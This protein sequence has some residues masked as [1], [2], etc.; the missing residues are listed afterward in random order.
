MKVLL[1]DDSVPAQNM[2]KKIL[3][4]AGYDVLTASNGLDAW[5]KIADSIP[6]IA[7]LDIFMPGYTGLEL[8]ARLRGAPN[9]AKLP[10]ILTVGKL[11]PYRPEDGEH[12]QSNAV[13]VK[14]FAANELISAVRSLI[15][16][17]VPAAAPEAE[18]LPLD[19][20]ADPLHGDPLP[21][22]PFAQPL[23]SHAAPPLA[24][25]DDVL[26]T[27]ELGDA[28]P[29]IAE[30]AAP[31][32][33]TAEFG[34]PE[35]AAGPSAEAA[36]STAEDEPLFSSFESA[37]APVDEPLVASGGFYGGTDEPL[38]GAEATAGEETLA[39]NPDAA[40]TPFSASTA[41]FL[42]QQPPASEG[43]SP[44]TE[45]DLEAAPLP[46]VA[47]ATAQADAPAIQAIEEPLL[48]VPEMAG[49]SEPIAQIPAEIVP[50]ALAH[51][52]EAVA[53]VATAAQPSPAFNPEA[54]EAARRQAFEELFSSS[55][56]IPLDEDEEPIALADATA[57]T[58]PAAGDSVQTRIF[59]M[60]NIAD[61]TVHEPL[62]VA[63]DSEL[64]PLGNGAAGFVSAEADPNLL[65]ESQ[66]LSTPAA[67]TPER[68]ILMD[69]ELGPVWGEHE[70][71]QRPA[72]SFTSALYASQPDVLGE[73]TPPQPWSTSE[74]TTEAASEVASEATLEAVPEAVPEFDVTQPIEAA[75]E[76]EIVQA[77][78][79][80]V[81]EF[82][83]EWAPEPLPAAVAATEEVAASAPEAAPEAVPEFVAQ[84]VAAIPESEIVEAVPEAVPEFVPE[85]ASE[86]VPVAV[87]ATEEVAASSPEA[88]PEAVPEFAAAVPEAASFEAAI[89]EAAPPVASQPEA[90]A[91]EAAPE[92]VPELA[93]IPELAPEP[94]PEP[95]PEASASPAAVE[96][97]PPQSK[98]H[99]EPELLPLSAAA[100]GLVA[101]GVAQAV[102]QAATHAVTH[103]SAPEVAIPQVTPQ[104]PHEAPELSQQPPEPPLSA[105]L[106]ATSAQEAPA[107]QLDME[108]ADTERIRLAVDRVFDRFK[109]LLV[110][111]IV[112]ELNHRD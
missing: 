5:R 112:R 61:S 76:A 88:A 63:P 20:A 70:D 24:D 35:F 107:P 38:L 94:V 42:P 10:V 14:P 2:G 83:Q 58:A 48:A 46:A 68:D 8:C 54:D 31:E 79:E 96:A 30:F 100:A 98:P 85:W 50:A 12:V 91:V 22:E 32:F 26:G 41:D 69:E 34:A 17:P 108:S 43:E 60:P 47:Q 36:Q 27:P 44:F 23:E 56:P 71:V 39:F 40:H 29:A 103:V 86:P 49:Q 59:R 28:E 65:E 52:A 66:P 97:I 13:I 110:K 11:E 73:P 9:T 45:F 53:E 3:V 1:A 101:A 33:G 51:P 81:P 16:S 21:A 72:E 55:E 87:A 109:N 82:V 75:P 84:P 105:T 95:A 92:A 6:D 37:P 99:L 102:A 25:S 80:A 4:D 90:E 74:V 18:S 89:R 111:A 93:A 106:S 77:A 19:S 57:E 7:I 64:E 62:D 78:P 15:G 67:Q 104:L